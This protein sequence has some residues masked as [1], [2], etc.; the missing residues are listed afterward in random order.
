M[1]GNERSAP[2]G[3]LDMVNCISIATVKNAVYRLYSYSLSSKQIETFTCA[4]AFFTRKAK[5]GKKH[6]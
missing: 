5:L 6:L 2:D 1:A 4:L 3:W